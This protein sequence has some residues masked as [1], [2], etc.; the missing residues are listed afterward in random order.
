MDESSKLLSIG[1]FSSLCRLSVRMLRHYDAHGVLVPHHVDPSSGYR[2]YAVSQLQ[3]AAVLRQLRDAG[4]GVSS[5]AVMLAA[6]GTSA[7]HEALHAQRQVL[8]AEL[9]AAQAR[10]AQLDRLL[11]EGTPMSITVELRTI[12][13]MTVV[14][15]RGTIPTYADEHLLW[16]RLMPALGAQGISPIGPCGVIEH[17]DAYTESDVDEEV[18]F[19]VAP[20]TNA[21]APLRVHSLPERRCAVARV[22]GP[23]DQIVTAHDRIAELMASESLM[24]LRDGTLASKGFNVYLTTPDQVPTA[25]LVTDVCVPVTR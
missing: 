10:L 16:Q 17:D 8:T 12:P 4:F 3:D 21:V 20:D 6:R 24:P 11:N 22:V 13:A 14:A 9:R 7:W 15:L 25:E 18:F 23:Y 2:H 5:L 19:P 1:E